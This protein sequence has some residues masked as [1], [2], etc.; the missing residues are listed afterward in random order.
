MANF[1]IKYGLYDNLSSADFLAGQVLVTTDTRAIYIDKPDGTTV[2]DRI[3]IGDFQVVDYL[4][5]AEKGAN[6][7]TVLPT[8]GATGTLEDAVGSQLYFVKS[9]NAL[10][11]A[12]GNEWIQ[13]NTDTDTG[14][15]AVAFSGGTGTAGAPA[16]GEY[17]SGASYNS[18]NR[19]ITF[20][21]SKLLAQNVE[22]TAAVAESSE[23]AGDGKAAV[24][25]K[26]QL[27]IL[28]GGNTVAGSVAKA[29]KDAKDYADGLVAGLDGS[30]TIASESDG[31][32]TIKAG[33]T[34]ADGVVDN[35][36]DSDI[37]LA[38]VAT[39]GN[40]ED[41]A[42]DNTDSGLKATDVQAAID[43]VAAASAGGV[44][45]KTIH[46]VDDTSNQSTYAK[47]YK[48]YQGSDS[49][50]MTNNTLIGTINTP[51]DKVVEDGSVVV[52]TYDST[53]GK[54]LEGSTDVTSYIKGTGTATSSDAGKYI[55]LV[56]QNVTDPLY[57]AA[58]DLVDIYTAEAN[59]S[60]IQIAI[61]GSNEISATIVA[62]SVGTTELA[63]DAVTGAKI[64]DDAVGAEHINITAHT[65]SQ[66]ASTDGLAISVTTTDGQ[67]SA[68]TGS[69]AANTYDTY[70]A[71]S[72]AKSEVIGTA[73]DTASDD[74]I[75]GAKAYAD[76]VVQAGM[77]WGTF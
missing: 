72:T 60:Q 32:V 7:G 59:A 61:S 65:E 67:V 4:D 10:A 31:V 58:Q 30:A 50:D 55:K 3:R 63:A 70:G 38:K 57:I 48:I 75:N 69:I 49:S 6:S 5:D 16:A 33:I 11:V 39:T 21:V 56:L 35:N 1:Q 41:V 68:V 26:D 8:K 73:S 34:E 19:T 71:A 23:G 37:T 18:A 2:A 62:G 27:D 64:A 54:L 22:Y 47:V 14:A 74:T 15:T 20:T 42:Y 76:S 46:F 17:V 12:K 9:K 51:K 77:A 25:V 28:T 43:E 36:S 40:A 52:V 45:S 24:S 66:T 53:E 44:D 29:E 13:I